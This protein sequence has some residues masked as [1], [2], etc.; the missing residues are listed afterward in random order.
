MYRMPLLCLFDFLQPK[1]IMKILIF[2]FFSFSMPLAVIVVVSNVLHAMY[3][4]CNLNRVKI[5]AQYY[6]N[7][8]S[9]ASSPIV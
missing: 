3:I 8:V 1:A 5:S 4:P 6:V 9:A 7:R 2:L